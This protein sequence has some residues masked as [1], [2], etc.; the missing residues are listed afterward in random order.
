MPIYKAVENNVHLAQL[1]FGYGDISVAHGLTEE[2]G[3]VCFFNKEEPTPVGTK[4]K[5]DKPIEVPLEET[6]VRMVFNSVKSLDVVIR[7]LYDARLAMV[8]REMESVK[9]IGENEEK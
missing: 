1:E 2:A 7:A 3:A 4:E 6:P 9:P 8:V 5:L